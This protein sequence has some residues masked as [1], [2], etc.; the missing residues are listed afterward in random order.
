[1]DD[2]ADGVRHFGFFNTEVALRRC[3]RCGS[4]VAPEPQWGTV[5]GS[6][7]PAEHRLGLC[8]ACRKKELAAGLVAGGRA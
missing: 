3:E 1:M 6:V 8:G 7:P 5:R 2:T 4:F